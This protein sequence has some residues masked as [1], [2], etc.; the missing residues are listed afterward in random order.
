LGFGFQLLL[1]PWP[2][3]RVGGD[4]R[5]EAPNEGALQGDVGMPCAC[6]GQGPWNL[7]RGIDA[8]RPRLQARFTRARPVRRACTNC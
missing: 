5:K 1:N 8:E 4:E 2:S 6:G 3:P 7:A